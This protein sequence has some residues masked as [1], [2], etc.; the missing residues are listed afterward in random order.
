MLLDEA[1]SALDTALRA[2]VREETLAVLREAGTPTLLVTHDAEEAIRVGDRI[3]AMQQGRIVQ[4]GTPVQLYA[5]PVDAFVAGFFGPV[6]RFP[7]R[8][9]GGLVARRWAG[10][11]APAGRGRGGRGDRPARGRSGCAS[12]RRL[13]PAGPRDLP[14]RSRAPCMSCAWACPMAARSRCGRWAE[15]LVETGDEVEIELDPRHLFVY[16]AAG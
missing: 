15:A 3:H 7:C 11:A 16:P 8:A 13:G 10:P 4:S 2:A 5:R 9:E 12:R 14:P 1:F 6:N